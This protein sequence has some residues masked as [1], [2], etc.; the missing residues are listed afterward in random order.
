MNSQTGQKP[1]QNKPEDVYNTNPWYLATICGTLHRVQADYTVLECMTAIEHQEEAG[2][3]S[4][5]LC[6][7]T[8]M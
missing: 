4:K 3:E 5:V 1:D 6:I 8:D 7:R 2:K